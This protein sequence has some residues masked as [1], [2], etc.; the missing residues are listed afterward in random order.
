[1]IVIADN[2]IIHK[3][4]LCNLLDEFLAWLQVPPSEVWVL[5]TLK[6]WVRRKL[7]GNAA[8]LS[9]FERFLL[10]TAEIPVA[11]PTTLEIFDALDPGEQQLLSVFIEQ[12]EPPRLVTGDKRALKQLAELSQQ[13]VLLSAMLK[14]Q[15]DCLE[16]VM[17]ELIRQFGFDAINSKI[18]PE[19][20]GVFK[21]AFGA[22]RTKAHVIEA[23]QSYLGE[24]RSVS[25]FVIARY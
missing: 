13:N 6:F 7:K 16:G 17:L 1:M 10:L 25:P 19:A 20:D 3:L 24:L 23:L 21:L 22:G 11:T 15:V 8:A 5:P 14:G 4:A 18:V 9:C 12:Q 2:D